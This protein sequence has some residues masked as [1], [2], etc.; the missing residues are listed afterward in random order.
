MTAAEPIWIEER[1][2]LALHDRLLVLHGGAAG[3][4]DEGLLRSALA[5]PRQLAAYGGDVD[6]IDSAAAYTE[7]I[8]RNH[9][10]VDGNKRTGFVVGVLFLEVN[11][12]R[13]TAP[14]PAAA[15]AVIGLASGIL[16]GAAY[17]AFLRA[18][19]TQDRALR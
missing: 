1:D 10:F 8:V 5:R 7:G 9:P 13:F 18:N 2:V 14:E 17:T 16:D 19:V 6:V 15:Q 12:Y 4:R 11:G 3:V